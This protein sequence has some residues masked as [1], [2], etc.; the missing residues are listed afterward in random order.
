M[1]THVEAIAIAG[2]IHHF[3]FGRSKRS[4]KSLSARKHNRIQKFLC[5]QDR[6]DI[7]IKIKR[8]HAQSFRRVCQDLVLAPGIRDA[9]GERDHPAQYFDFAVERLLLICKNSGFGIKLPDEL[10]AVLGQ[11]FY[12]IGRQQ[13]VV[14]ERGGDGATVLVVF[15]TGLDVVISVSSCLE[16]VNPNDLITR[17]AGG[18]RN[19]GIG[20]LEFAL[21]LRKSRREFEFLARRG[22]KVG[23]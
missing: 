10:V 17:Q 15:E 11:D 5:L 3:E 19:F 22:N 13:L 12:R 4:R 20:M 1:V 14:A 7:E 8:V 21:A 9:A 18:E 6:S 16:T 23:Y 2:E